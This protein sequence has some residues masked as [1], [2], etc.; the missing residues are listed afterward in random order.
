MVDACEPYR[1]RLQCPELVGRSPGLARALAD[2]CVAARCDGPVLILGDTGTGK[3]VLAE[4]IHRAS[5]RGDR[6][7]VKMHLTVPDGLVDAHVFGA[8]P[9]AYTGLVRRLRGFVERAHGTTLFI[10]ELGALTPLG[11]SKLLTLVQFGTFS[12]LGSTEE[13]RADVRVIAATRVDPRELPQDLRYRLGQFEIRMPSL[14]ERVEDVPLLA[15]DVARRHARALGEPRLPIA[16]PA[17]RLLLAHDWPGNVRELENVVRRGLERAWDQGATDLAAGHVQDERAPTPA[18]A[19][20][21]DRLEA[22]AAWLVD[23]AMIEAD[24]NVARAAERLG[25]STSWLYKHLSRRLRR[26]AA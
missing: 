10:D 26:P 21:F 5:G 6:A 1:A 14:A 17:L 2:A 13:R 25:T 12:P 4:A 19:G 3:N 15:E 18:R 16:D 8:E 9:G 20:I 7:L 23:R 22:Y 24:D 11:Q